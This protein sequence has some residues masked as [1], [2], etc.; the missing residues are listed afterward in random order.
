[1]G[2]DAGASSQWENLPKWEGPA[3]ASILAVLLGLSF[4]KLAGI[5]DGA[6]YWFI[7]TV[8]CGLYIDPLRYRSWRELF[9]SPPPPAPGLVAPGLFFPARGLF[10]GGSPP[11]VG[12]KVFFF[13]FSVF[14]P[15]P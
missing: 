1:M 15:F 11:G 6:L 4:Q 2:S 3:F 10:G 8:F 5:F 7:F 13:K 12:E 14:A 9:L